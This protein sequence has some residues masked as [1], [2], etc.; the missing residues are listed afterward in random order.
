M[1]DSRE[2]IL[3]PNVQDTITFAKGDDDYSPY[4]CQS[5]YPTK[6]DTSEA[7]PDGPLRFYVA[8]YRK[9]SNG[10]NESFY[11]VKEERSGLLRHI[12]HRSF[13]CGNFRRTS[14]MNHAQVARQLMYFHKFAQRQRRA[15]TM[16]GAERAPARS[17]TDL[18]IGTGAWLALLSIR[19]SIHSLA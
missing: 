9:Q 4:E 16:A 6:D 7:P 15:T 3:V 2:L 10:K 14:K 5:S 18:G 12:F 8:V 1:I 17:M 11:Q 13:H 19:N